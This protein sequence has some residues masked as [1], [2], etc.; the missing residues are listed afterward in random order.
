MESENQKR[1]AILT[2]GIY[3][4]RVGG[5]QKHSY[6]L[7]KHLANKN[8]SV[9]IF[10]SNGGN[11]VNL[12]NY[13]SNSELKQIEFNFIEFPEYLRFPS[14]YII[15]SY[16]FSKEIHK[17]IQLKNNFDWIYAQGFTSWYFLKKNPNQKN[18]VSNLHGLEMFQRS[19]GF[20]DYIRKL[21]LRIPAKQIIK[22]S[23]KQVSLGGKLS[24]ILRRQGA[25]DES[26]IEL[27]NGID[28]SWILDVSQLSEVEARK[29]R[30][31][32][33]IFI[34][35]YERRKGIE[36]FHN[37]IQKT[38][39][40]LR[41]EVVFVGPIP[42]NKRINHPKVTY[43]GEVRDSNVI[44]DKLKN[45][46]VL[47]SPS[48]SEGMPTVILEAMASGCVVIATNVGANNTMVDEKNGW[49]I[50]EGI[51]NGLQKSI[52]QA[53]E[54]PDDKLYGMKKKSLKRV[55]ENFTW[56]RVIQKTI[57]ELSFV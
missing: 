23:N 1:V 50:N 11:S 32:K 8:I 9:T 51:I 47:V 42:E 16:F 37:V 5:I 43:L 19:S 6:Y 52:Q 27:P 34:G 18:V 40:N 22:N 53:V 46:D 33:F 13:F 2:N 56:E 7:A 31:C 26:V 20:I 30:T 21:L 41:Y 55:E 39:D 25:K 28:Q 35:R 45:S 44:K 10:S 38:I 3:P 17:K 57:K 48:Y 15:S 14:H 36:E 54:I 12:N 29:N 49:L 24:E 4:Y